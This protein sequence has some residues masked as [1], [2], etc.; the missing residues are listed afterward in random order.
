MNVREDANRPRILIVEDEA[1]LSLLLTYNLEAEGYRVERCDR[2]DVISEKF[3]GSGRRSL[4]TRDHAEHRRFA[5]TGWPQHREKFARGNVE[6]DAIHGIHVAEG[7]R[8]TSQPDGWLGAH[9][10]SPHASLRM[11]LTTLVGNS[12]LCHKGAKPAFSPRHGNSFLGFRVD[13]LC[14]V[15]NRKH[16]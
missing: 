2:G 14:I 11:F 16:V 6:V 15:A 10:A 9:S 8:Q 3:N 5:G 1:A 7:F 4:E 13:R 12:R